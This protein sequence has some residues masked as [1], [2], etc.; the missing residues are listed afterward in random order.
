MTT[1][2]LKIKAS[3]ESAEAQYIQSVGSVGPQG[4]TGA[5]GPSGW[6]NYG[7]MDVATSQTLPADAV[8]VVC[9][10]AAATAITV[11]LPE[12]GTTT[13]QYIT[14]VNTSA[15]AATTGTVTVARAVGGALAD[16]LV[17]QGTAANTYAIAT[18]GG[19]VTLVADPALSVWRVVSRMV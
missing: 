7:Y 13:K 15:D 17:G 16:T 18:V 19:S 1:P 10:A 14:I 9:K 8:F 5:A 12:I 11:T 4:N 3:F 6:A 2:S